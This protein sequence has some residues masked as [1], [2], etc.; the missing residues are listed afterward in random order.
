MI[1]RKLDWPERMNEALEDARARGFS[2]SYYCA[3]FAADVVKAMTGA[4]LLPVRHDTVADAY[5]HMR[6]SH[7]T[8]LEAMEAALGDP[9]PVAFAQRGDV[10][11]NDDDGALAIGICCG[12]DSA[13][14][15]SDGGLAFL[16]TLEQAKAFR[17]G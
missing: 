1:A 7:K 13:F 10:V 8:I 4:D 14:V 6:K 11:Y 16:P 3:A 2:E 9:I 17:V 12:T 5:A 15:S